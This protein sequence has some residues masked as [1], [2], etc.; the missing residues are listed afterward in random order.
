VLFREYVKAFMKIKVEASGL[1]SNIL[2]EKDKQNW[3]KEYKN[4]L[5]IDIDLNNVDLN[6]GL[7]HMSK[8]VVFLFLS[9]KKN[10]Y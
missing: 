6:P 7:R 8:L 3:Q 1:P 5:D 10:V 9:A 2:T 4:R